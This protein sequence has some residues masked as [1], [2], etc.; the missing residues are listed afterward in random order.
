[1]SNVV[2]TPIVGIRMPITGLRVPIHLNEPLNW[3]EQFSKFDNYIKFAA[4]Q[5]VS[6]MDYCFYG[7]DDLYQEGLLL[8]WQCF[9]RYQYKSKQEFQ[10][11]FKSS[12]WRLLRDKAGKPNKETTDIDEVFE[13]EEI[14]YSDN[15][16]EDMY[17]EY[18]M[19]QVYELLV[20]NPTAISILKELLNPSKVTVEEC[21][22]DMAR[23][24]MLK[25]QGA[26]LNV[27]TSIEIKPVHIQRALNLTEEIYAKNFKLVQMAIYEVYARDCDIKSY[28]PNWDDPTWEELGYNTTNTTNYEIQVDN[29]ALTNEEL[30]TMVQV[31][32]SDVDELSE[33]DVEKTA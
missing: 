3:D 4:K 14:G 8:L 12:L 22:K 19:K 29:P 10:Y 15:S 33:S 21:D 27:P 31:I 11:L 17:E 9:D 20:G 18:R 1:M 28:I 16:L 25:N 26:Q 32:M 5:V 24:E 23:K 2:R 7:A 6:N 30:D 13:A